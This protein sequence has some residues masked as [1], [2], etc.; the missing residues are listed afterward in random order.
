MTKKTK[1]TLFYA[2]VAVFLMLSYVIIL[3]AQG[4]K[5]SF[6][7]GTF[8][9]TGAISIKTNT[10]A[11]VFL[12]DKL[13]GNTSFF[14]NSFSIDRLLPGSYEL[15]IQKDNYTFWKK[16]VIVEEGLV[17]D[18]PNILLLPEEGEEEQRL[19]EE[20][21]LSFKALILSPTPTSPARTP[22][23]STSPSPTP[24]LNA[25]PFTLDLKTGK[26]FQNTEQNRKELA[27]DVKGFRFSE[28]E[29]K[30]AWWTANELWIYWLAD[31]NYQP[32]HEANDKELIT[33]FVQP[34]QNGV[35]FRGEDHLVLELE[36]RD[37][38]DR[39]YSIFKM[40][41]ID[42]RGGLNIVEL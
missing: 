20:V 40:I 30:L 39:P 38:K 6:A 34:I 32:F 25:E 29:N 2:A 26:L 35:W 3:Y 23:S 13:E 10:G 33:R 36:A 8:Q 5:Y 28:N 12:D 24:D 18:F 27:N 7:E 37:S 22:R 41:E 9:R 19:F 42:K 16:T 31:Q 4:Y 11:K 21:D 17:V 1:R 14:N 15:Y